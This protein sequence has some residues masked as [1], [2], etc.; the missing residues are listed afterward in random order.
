MRKITSDDLDFLDKLQSKINTQDTLGTRTP[1]YWAIKNM[2]YELDEE[3]NNHNKELTTMR[4]LGDY[5]AEWI[6]DKNGESNLSD[7]DIESM[8]DRLKAA[9]INQLM[10]VTNVEYSS[11]GKELLVTSKPFDD[12]DD[13]L[14]QQQTIREFIE[15]HTVDKGNY[16]QFGDDSYGSVTFESYAKV[17]YIVENAMFL[18]QE[19]A[20]KYLET[21][22]HNYSESAHTYCMY[23]S[24]NPELEQLLEII[25]QTDWKSV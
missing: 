20:D 23:A 13:E 5:E 6:L 19:S 4:L 15:E 22:S 8:L 11:N 14:I 18:T 7:H 2:R 10:H 25:T 12:E 21:N 17:P 24:S 16:R 3:F 9:S 1:N